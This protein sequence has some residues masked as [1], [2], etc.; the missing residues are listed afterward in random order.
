MGTRAGKTGKMSKFAGFGA[1]PVIGAGAAA[2]AAAVTI[3]VY[4][5]TDDPSRPGPAPQVP[6]EEASEAGGEAASVPAPEA[7]D[8]P[9]DDTTPAEAE[10]QATPPPDPPALDTFRLEADGQMLV[11]GRAVPGG[12]VAITLDNARIGTAEADGSG[13]FVAFLDHP[14]S[15]AA[16]VLGLE[17]LLD[18]GGVIR[19]TDEVLIAPTPRR[20]PQPEAVAE[21]RSTEPEPRPEPVAEAGPETTSAASGSET[22]GGAVTGTDA[23]PVPEPEAVAETGTDPAAPPAPEP[24]TEEGKPDEVAVAE[25]G[26]DPAAPP[27]SASAKE[28]E[29]PV[30]VAEAADALDGSTQEAA[31]DVS[32]AAPELAAAEPAASDPPA[33]PA[34]SLNGDTADAAAQP[35]PADAPAAPTV[36]LSDAQGVRVLQ[37]PAE[38][39]T[40]VMSSVAL[41][42][43]SYSDAGEVQLS[44]RASAPDASVRIYLDNRAVTTAPVD[45]TGAWRSALPE[46]D[47]GVYTL[48]VDE[49]GASGEVTSRVETPFKREDVAT[50]SAQGGDEDVTPEPPRMSVVT[51]QPGS[52]LWAIS[53]ETYGEGI[54]YVR[55]YEAN[56]ERIRD[57]DLIYPGQVFELPD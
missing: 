1:G 44:G 45:A 54:L 36:M 14:P 11:A 46:V 32:D 4:L 17:L 5:S 39:G 48:R 55:V 52:T 43:I 23:Q 26:S 12:R 24:A 8:P 6:V 34:A 10:A 38:R 15:D 27:V 33:P 2:V 13:K 22:G 28:E 31:K 41:D 3:G 30:Q 56:R 29:K 37:A 21:A 51:V 42:A 35:P 7:A 20:A 53:R 19:A 18:D 49:V 16:R 57:P 40:E 47:T 50:L 25:T 9:K